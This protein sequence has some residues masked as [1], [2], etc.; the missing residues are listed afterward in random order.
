MACRKGLSWAPRCWERVPNV[1]HNWLEIETW[2]L[3]SQVTTFLTNQINFLQGNHPYVFY[4]DFEK[5]F[6]PLISILAVLRCR[7]GLLM[8][9]RKKWFQ[10]TNMVLRNLSTIFLVS[11]DA[12]AFFF[13]SH[14]EYGWNSVTLPLLVSQFSLRKH[15]VQFSKIFGSKLQ[16]I[17]KA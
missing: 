6:N 3:H 15:H 11:V 4:G 9:M 17:R 13:F 8:Q 5:S 1:G 10:C 12:K 16:Q 14:L 2:Y 7:H